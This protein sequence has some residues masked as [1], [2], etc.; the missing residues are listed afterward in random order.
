[1]L[2]FEFLEK[3]GRWPNRLLSCVFQ[4]L[5]DAFP[6]LGASGNVERRW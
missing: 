5:P 6:H 4:P 2:T 3:L 1:M